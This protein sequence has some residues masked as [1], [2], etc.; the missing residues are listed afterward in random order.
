MAR[1]PSFAHAVPANLRCARRQGVER[2]SAGGVASDRLQSGGSVSLFSSVR[3]SGSPAD[4]LAYGKRDH[5][6]RAAFRIDSS[7]TGADR[8]E[9]R[10]HS[11]V[12][13]I[14]QSFWR[15]EFL[16][17]RQ[18]GQCSLCGRLFPVDFLVMA[19]IKR[20]AECSHEERL[21]PYNVIPMCL[22]GCDACLRRSSSQSVTMGT[23]RSTPSW[24]V[25]VEEATCSR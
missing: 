25:R 8:N 9:P 18:N 13:R 6:T 12:G 15:R 22:F 7:T 24:H 20:R 21:D 11:I 1:R 10:V 17:D 23:R 16:K 3:R 5:D 14:E 19:H 4:R 2:P